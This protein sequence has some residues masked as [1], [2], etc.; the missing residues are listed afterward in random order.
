MEK[1][2]REVGIIV[3]VVAICILV[4]AMLGMI[5]MNRTKKTQIKPAFKGTREMIL[6]EKFVDAVNRGSETGIADT[7]FYHR[8]C[9]SEEQLLAATKDYKDV[10]D[11]TYTVNDIV[12]KNKRDS[13]LYV[14]FRFYKNGKAYSQ[15]HTVHMCTY[16]H[17]D[18]FDNNEERANTL[19][20]V[21]WIDFTEPL[22]VEDLDDYEIICGIN[23]PF[24]AYFNGV[25]DHDADTILKA[26]R[27]GF[28]DR[29]QA[30]KFI[31]DVTFF[32]CGFSEEDMRRLTAPEMEMYRAEAGTD[33]YSQLYE[34]NLTV[35]Y[36]LSGSSLRHK[37]VSTVLVGQ[38]HDEEDKYVFVDWYELP[39]EV[40]ND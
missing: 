14:H 40:V 35:W 36:T 22:D 13:Y 3:T 34:V 30:E 12:H 18:D 32:Q 9:D 27:P 33:E 7:Y 17:E 38:Y 25:Y 16:G 19:G 29:A 28:A 11:L 15:M 23:E 20:I 8:L 21:E 4:G 39:Y 24:D 31:S 10:K 2:K 37:G 1:K 26:Y 6:L 5:F